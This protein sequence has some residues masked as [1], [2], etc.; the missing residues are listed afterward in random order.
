MEWPSIAQSY[1][2]LAS[3][4]RLILFDK[5]G[6]GMSDPSREDRAPDLETRMDDVRGFTPKKS[7]Q[8]EQAPGGHGGVRLAKKSQHTAGAARSRTTGGPGQRRFDAPRAVQLTHQAPFQGSSCA[9]LRP[10]RRS[11]RR[12]VSPHQRGVSGRE[13]RTDTTRS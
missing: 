8:P 1:R 3:F 12:S 11:T 10:P 9:D 7:P 4:S 2:S 6:T 13:V 5:R